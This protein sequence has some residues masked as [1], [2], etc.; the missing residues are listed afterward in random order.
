MLV[1]DL[2]PE[3]LTLEFVCLHKNLRDKANVK[4]ESLYDDSLINNLGPD[5]YDKLD[6]MPL[7]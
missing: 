6:N 2:G 1:K 7:L 4:I 5:M 3:N